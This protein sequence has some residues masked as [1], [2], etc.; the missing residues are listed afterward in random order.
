MLRA[1]SSSRRTVVRAVLAE[2]PELPADARGWPGSGARARGHDGVDEALYRQPN[3][4]DG[5]EAHWVGAVHPDWHQTHPRS[6][7]LLVTVD[8]GRRV[9]EPSSTSNPLPGNHGM[10][11][12][13][14]VPFV[15]AGGAACA[16]RSPGRPPT[17]RRAPEQAEN[18]DIAPTA[19]WLLGVAPP[20]DGPAGREGFDG[21]V[22]SEAFTSRP[23]DRCAAKA[24]AAAPVTPSAAPATTPTPTP[25]P[26]P[27]G[28]RCRPPDLP[29]CVCRRRVAP[30]SRRD[31]ETPREDLTRAPL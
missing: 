27:R 13:L 28:A 16:P 7:D 5:G 6:G 17:P 12:T 23:A 1:G 31:L 29:R 4:A 14:R 20:A 25:G 8:D 26:S 11:S 2:G 24:V 10:P 15:P 30:G 21:R 9:S 22:L 18:V 19:A 3:P